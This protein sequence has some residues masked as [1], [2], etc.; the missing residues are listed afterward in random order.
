M[1]AGRMAPFAEFSG[2]GAVFL[3]QVSGLEFLQS[4]MHQIEGAVD[5]L[6]GLFGGHG[7]AG[8][9]TEPGVGGL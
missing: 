5:Q 3:A 8:G 7:R 2:Q 4:L 1:T 6:G 9:G